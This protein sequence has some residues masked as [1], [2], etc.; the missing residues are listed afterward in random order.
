MEQT[1]AFVDVIEMIPEKIPLLNDTIQNILTQTFECALYIQE[2]TE[3][4]FYGAYIK[5]SHFWPI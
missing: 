3:N 5:V 4:G 2:Y 1:Y